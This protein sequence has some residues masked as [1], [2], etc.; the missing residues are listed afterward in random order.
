MDHFLGMDR[1]FSNRGKVML[2]LLLWALPVTLFAQNR[3]LDP[4]LIITT[5][6]P[7]LYEISAAAYWY[8]GTYGPAGF[9][10][11]CAGTK[12]YSNNL[13]GYQTSPSGGYGGFYAYHVYMGPDEYREY[14]ADTILALQP[15]ATYKV[16][17][18]VSLSDSSLYATDGL[19]VLFTVNR[20]IEPT[21]FHITRTPQVDFSHFGPV[22]EK[23][24]WYTL[25]DTFVADSAYEHLTIGNFKDDAATRKVMQPY[26]YRVPYSVADSVAYYYIDSVSV[27]RIFP[28]AAFT[29]LPGY[30]SVNVYANPKRGTVIFSLSGKAPAAC[31]VA[32]YNLQG[33]PVKVQHCTSTTLVMD[34]SG[35]PGGYYT[36]RVSTPQAL[37]AKGGLLVNG[38]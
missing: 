36:Y 22:T 17:V 6:C 30:P 13:F 27:E 7:V 10:N 2:L 11:E 26:H 9:F 23:V 24:N 37:I 32:L 38:R 14:L 1:T 31:T 21:L 28:A 12:E 8:S 5:S 15:G 16:T 29:S 34:V 18:I 3:V 19:G 25:V 20:Y 35:L 33:L 4:S